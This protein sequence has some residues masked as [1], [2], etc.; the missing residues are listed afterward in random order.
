MRL[1]PLTARIIELESK[2]ASLDDKLHQQQIVITREAKV[3]TSKKEEQ[4]LDISNSSNT[5]CSTVIEH[6]IME[7]PINPTVSNLKHHNNIDTFRRLKTDQSDKKSNNTKEFVARKKYNYKQQEHWL[8]EDEASLYAINNFAL[9][10]KFC[11]TVHKHGGVS[12]YV[13]QSLQASEIKTINDMSREL[14]CEVTAVYVK[15]VNLVVVVVYRSPCSNSDFTTFYNTLGD[16]LHKFNNF[17]PGAKLVICGDFNVNFLSLDNRSK[18]ITDLMLQSSLDQTV[19]ECT[20]QLN[21]SKTCPDNIFCNFSYTSAKVISLGI[22]DHDPQLLTF[23]SHS[24]EGDDGIKVTYRKYNNSTVDVF[25][26][27]LEQESWTDVYEAKTASAKVEAFLNI[28]MFHFNNSFPIREIHKVNKTKTKLMTPEL[29]RLKDL[30]LLYHH[31]YKHNSSEE[32]KRLYTE[33]KQRYDKLLKDTKIAYNKNVIMNSDN[34]AKAVWNVHSHNTRNKNNL[35]Q[36]RGRIEKTK[37]IGIDLYN[38]L[39]LS[40]TNLPINLFE[41]KIKTVLKQLAPYSINDFKIHLKDNA[42]L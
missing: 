24:S 29:Y 3:E 37:L 11:R 4:D 18:Q 30:L 27:Y 7:H 36:P 14:H 8:C 10:S 26:S 40:I 5:S 16:I 15:Q 6:E 1:S 17:Y 34:K 23:R 12:I 38:L 2:I 28:F 41:R 25:R 39:P 9:K 20:R 19:F 32:N 21:G 33:C 22:S 42:G 31:N 13:H 35:M